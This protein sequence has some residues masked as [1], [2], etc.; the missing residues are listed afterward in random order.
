MSFD[1]SQF[2]KV[3]F[4]E[5]FEGLDVMEQALLSISDGQP[6]DSELINTIF[7]AAHSIKGGSATLGFNPITDFTHILETLLDEVRA[8]SRQLPP[9]AIKLLLLSCDCIREMISALD[10]G[11]QINPDSASQLAQQFAVL[12]ADPADNAESIESTEPSASAVPADGGWQILFKPQPQ[13]LLTGNEPLR[14][15]RELAQLG[16]LQVSVDSSGLPTFEQLTADECHLSWQLQLQ[17][18]ASSAEIMEVFDWVVDECQLE[19]TP[20][21]QQAAVVDAV[22][23]GASAEQPSAPT[24]MPAAS[25]TQPS[26]QQV[27]PQQ[28]QQQAAPAKAATPAAS[29]SAPATAG[30]NSIRVG[31]D[32][33]DSLINLVGEL[34]ITQSMLSELGNDFSMNKLER[35][36]SGLDQLQQNTRELQESVMQI[37][38]LPISFAFNRF[39]RMIRDLSERIGKKVELKLS[40]EQTELDKTVM[41]QI[42]DPLVHL[43]RNA[44]DHGLESPEQ[45]LAAGKPEVGSIELNAYHKGGNI[46]IEIADD[47]RG[48]DPQSI[49]NKAIE[50]GLVGSE[51]NLSEQQIYE[52][53]FEPGF[54]TAEQVSDISGRGVGMDVV[55]KNI[56]A[57][58]GRIEIHSKL[59]EGSRFRV[60]LPLTLAILDGQLVRVGSE[61]Y[62]IPLITIVESLQIKQELVNRVSGNTVL[63]RL[64]E[65]NVPIIPLYQEFEI[66]AE[67]T[68]LD[69]ALLVVVE[70]DGHKVGLLVDDLLAQQQVVIKS[71]ENNYQ[72]IEGISGATILGDGSVALILDIPG[73][74]K[75]ASQ[76][77]LSG[78]KG[79]AA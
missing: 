35:L 33:I 52:L 34:V 47:G 22:D 24:P 70:G 74:I 43:V 32:K 66:E 31:I 14:I 9:D 36:A 8:G 12:L 68:S 62:I 48:I 13:I 19:L 73:L 67:H 58:G 5:S 63:Y 10:H 72:R 18:S 69:N 3:F 41:E 79:K 75:R 54:S 38:M 65:D 45:R 61:V 4:E 51:Q 17:T 6:P 25:N 49:L 42:N 53:I 11:Q 39:P 16:E 76:R 27:S 37:R 60:F 44:V 40:G 28:S 29:S 46:V 57:L 15:F 77:V 2:H 26:S 59:G 20:L 7:R 55:R 23:T 50:K 64:R 78:H 21:Q 71:L 1:M 56:K 30:N